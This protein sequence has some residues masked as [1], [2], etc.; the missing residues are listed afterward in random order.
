MKPQALV[1]SDYHLLTNSVCQ[2]LHKVGCDIGVVSGD[3]QWKTAPYNRLSLAQA[4]L[5][6]YVFV[7]HRGEPRKLNPD[8]VKYL[9]LVSAKVVVVFTDAP[10][11]VDRAS[12]P[13]ANI[14]SR[15]KVFVLAD[16]LSSKDGEV[17]SQLEKQIINAL[18]KNKI[19]VDKDRDIFALTVG[20]ATAEMVKELFTYWAPSFN[21]LGNKYEWRDLFSLLS[22]LAPNLS[23]LGPTSPLAAVDYTPTSAK[24][25]NGLSQV[26]EFLALSHKPALPRVPPEIP[27]APIKTDNKVKQFPLKIRTRRVYFVVLGILVFLASPVVGVILS[28][29]TLKMSAQALKAGSGVKVNNLARASRAFSSY[30]LYTSRYLPGYST[31]Y[32]LADVEM[33]SAKILTKSATALALSKSIADGVLGKHDYNLG[34]NARDLEILLSDAYVN[35]SS[36]LAR[37]NA[38]PGFMQNLLKGEINE[39]RV[40]RPYVLSASKIASRLPQLLGASGSKKYLV[41]LQNNMELRPTGG[42]IGSFA[43]ATFDRGKLIDTEIM[44][45]YAADG[46]LQGHVE[47][48]AP[49]KKH[50]G[51]ANWYLRDSNWS[52]DFPPSAARAEWF[53][54]KTINRSVDGVVGINLETAKSLLKVI[55][56]IEILD[57]GDT[58]NENNM[59]EKLQYEVENDF[60]PGSKKKANYLTALATSLLESVKDLQTGE[61][62]PMLKEIRARLEAGDIQIFVHDTGVQNILKTLGWSGEFSEKSCVGNCEDIL[63][64]V[65]EANLGVNKA[66]YHVSRESRATLAYAQG[67]LEAELVVSISNNADPNSSVPENRYKNYIRALAPAGAIFK[68]SETLDVQEYENRTEAGMLVDINPGESKQVTFNWSLKSDI[69]FTKPG[70]M[71]VVYWKQPGV[72][73]AATTISLRFPDAGEVVSSPPLSLTGGGQVGYNT[74]LAGIFKAEIRWKGNK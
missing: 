28:G 51:E 11:P 29:L 35:T 73:E 5:P 70:L 44:D 21:Y 4:P 53:L 3:S 47:P 65:V 20:D 12:Y 41:L 42:F 55:G 34:D 22:H 36:L 57:Y 24:E 38:L 26:V 31:V 74:N 45:V 52:P 56:D 60:F 9:D 30:S 18:E 40:A 32:Q 1:I 25:N 64:G 58:V 68:N 46:Q 62:E 39:L 17:D 49:I 66:N 71:N 7:L 19:T 43:I 15:A 6:S 8:V 37:I 14:S 67:R 54:D 10:K 16:L 63:L 72:S 59:Y 50:L 23:V 69:N 13:F 27:R 2:A 48:P 33:M 61:Y